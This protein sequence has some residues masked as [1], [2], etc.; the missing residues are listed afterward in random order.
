MLAID[1]AGLVG[2]D[3]P[4]HAGSFDL[5]F[6]RC[7]PNMLIAAPSDENECRLLL[8][9][10]FLHNGPS[11]VRYPRGSGGG[12]TLSPSLDPVEIGKGVLRRSGHNVALVAF[13]SLVAPA[14]A[15]AEALD[16]SVADMR[17]VKP[18]DLDLLRELAQTHRLLVTLEENAVAG[19]AGAGVAEALA[20]LGIPVPV[21]HLGLPDI[22]IEH[23]DPVRMLADCGLDAVGIERAVHRR[24]TL[25]PE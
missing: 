2:A 4:T 19:G 7:I 10:A 12:A 11:A 21:L 3:G 16:A 20:E 17:F 25:L 1:R 22:F 24:I 15:A 13:G 14:L 6:L 9:T 23:G 5:S 18:L 8:T